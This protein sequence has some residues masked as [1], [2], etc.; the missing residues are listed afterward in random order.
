MHACTNIALICFKLKMQH[1]ERRPGRLARAEL[2]PTWSASG[3][4]LCDDE[5]H[6]T[7]EP[8]HLYEVDG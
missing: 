3:M 7:G 8:G 1:Q 5:Q 2:S 6:T 4:C